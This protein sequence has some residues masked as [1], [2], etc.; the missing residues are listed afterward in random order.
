MTT[1]LKFMVGSFAS[2]LM[3]AWFFRYDERRVLGTDIRFWL[4]LISSSLFLLLV[5]KQGW[6][7]PGEIQVLSAIVLGI[8][9]LLFIRKAACC[10]KFMPPDSPAQLGWIRLVVCLTL[11][12]LV[13]RND[14]TATL[15]APPELLAHQGPLKHLFATLPQIFDIRS[16]VF[17]SGVWWTACISLPLGALG[18]FSWLTLPI[19]AVSFTLFYYA[20]IVY[21]HFF[22]SGFIP[23]Q[24]LYVLCFFPAGHVLSADAA[25]AG[26][27][28]ASQ[29]FERGDRFGLA[30]FACALVYGG[31]YYAAALSK[32]AADPIWIMPQNLKHITAEDSLG[33]ID[34]VFGLNLVPDLIRAGMP[35]LS[36]SIFAT[37]ALLIESSGVMIPF[38]RRARHVVP[39]L[40]WCLHAGIYFGNKLAFVDLLILPIM[41]IDPAWI[42]HRWAGT[43]EQRKMTTCVMPLLPLPR[44]RIV[45]AVFA[46]TISGGWFYNWECYP[47]SSSWSMYAESGL[48]EQ[49][50]YNRLYAVS[51]SGKRWATDMTDAVPWLA[52]A[53][54]QDLTLFPEGDDPKR[55]STLDRLFRN[56]AERYNRDLGQKDPIVAIEFEL[57]TWNY[58][59]DRGSSTYGNLTKKVTF[60]LRSEPTGIVS[61][62]LAVQ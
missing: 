44:E 2:S 12:V 20:Q 57:W 10:A 17:L 23:L 47:V 5:R 18:A 62:P 3:W 59:T 21:T 61:P 42:F 55:M 7:L 36:F 22:H 8:G 43:S 29:D 26:R 4:G 39:W 41:F 56:Y 32:W 6:K 27:K 49:I 58:S 33:L 38:S 40:I 14:I 30:V 50:R 52:T 16:E 25:R 60:D 9:V 15:V 35:D 45:V 51:R 13:L 46:A 19:A 11:W 31:S 28:L 24:I 48:T 1:H 54:W 34:H 53:K 37:V